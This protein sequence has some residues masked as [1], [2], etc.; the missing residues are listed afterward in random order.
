MF[1]GL[2]LLT[3]S[4]LTG[5]TERARTRHVCCA[6]DWTYKVT[7][8]NILFLATNNPGTYNVRWKWSI[9]NFKAESTKTLLSPLKF[10]WLITLL[11]V[12]HL[13]LKTG[14]TVAQLISGTRA[15]QYPVQVSVSDRDM[16]VSDHEFTC[17]FYKCFKEN[18]DYIINHKR[19][20][21]NK[22]QTY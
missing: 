1:T 7:N 11:L 16:T 19:C 5:N 3:C 8:L 22:T 10:W 17:R 6:C 18:A 12:L 14:S 15:E 2:S 20:T 21:F 9:R 4:A 13:S